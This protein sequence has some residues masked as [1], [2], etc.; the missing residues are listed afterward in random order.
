[1]LIHKFKS[2]SVLATLAIGVY[3]P[4]VLAGKAMP[5]APASVTIES[6]INGS[7]LGP[8]VRCRVYYE[9]SYGTKGDHA[10]LYLDDKQVATLHRLK[11]S[12]IL[13]QMEPGKHAICI[14]LVT[15][16]DKPIGV[17]QCSEISVE[18][19]AEEFKGNPPMTHLH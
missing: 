5:P 4:N 19:K 11:D 18:T 6:P 9:L 1:M 13:E 14:K 3:A 2:L 17:Q 10:Q 7:K 8:K 12:Q 16:N 15:R